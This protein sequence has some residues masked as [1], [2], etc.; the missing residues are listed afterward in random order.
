MSFI[1]RYERTLIDGARRA[2]AVEHAPPADP[3]AP[4]RQPRRPRRALWAGGLL[5]AAGTAAVLAIPAGSTLSPV[6]EARAALTPGPAILHFKVRPISQPPGGG[7]PP[8]CMPTEPSEFW[9]TTTA[10]LAVKSRSGAAADGTACDTGPRLP[11]D[12]ELL[13]TMQTESS[14]AEGAAP[15]TGVEVHYSPDLRHAVKL[16]GVRTQDVGRVLDV[17]APLNGFVATDATDPQ[18]ALRKLLAAP[19]LRDEGESTDASGQKVRTFV[20]PE[21]TFDGDDAARPKDGTLTYVVDAESYAPKRVELRQ[22][23]NTAAPGEPARFEVF[24]TGFVFDSWERLPLDDKHR[25]LLEIDLPAGASVVTGTPRELYQDLTRE[26]RLAREQTGK[27]R[28][29]AYLAEQR[30]AQSTP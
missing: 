30:S 28:L 1:D 3:P 20:L 10:P 12:T 29:Q 13:P 11:D 5:A 22:A 24:T 6:D 25:R 17:T 21:P 8:A 23:T 15:D 2:A 26:E 18:A 7:A 19:N 16:T 27:A 14:F 9:Q 4:A